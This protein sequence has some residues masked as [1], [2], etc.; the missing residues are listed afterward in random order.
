MK[1]QWDK[2]YLKYSLY[3]SLTIILAIIFYQVLDNLKSIYSSFSGSFS[4]VRRILSPFIIGGFIAYILN[5]GVRWFEKN[6]YSHSKFVVGKY[7]FHRMISILTVYILLI[8][9]IAMLIVF[10][11]PQISNNIREIVRRVPEYLNMTSDWL[12]YW[13]KDL[14]LESQYNIAEYIE[15]N[16]K[17]IFNRTSQIL[18][19][20]L[21]NFAV[22]VMNVTSG[23]LNFLL[24]LII[25]FYMLTDK[26]SF[27]EASEKFLRAIMK[28]EKVDRI[29]DF[30]RDAD[31]LFSKFII[32][33]SLDSF[34][35]G[36]ICLIGLSIM[37]IRYALL[38]S[39]IIGITNMIPYFGPFIGG[40]PATII[41]FFDSPIK[42]IWVLI[43]ILAL[44]QFD[45][46]ILG[47]KILG[48]S[49]GLRPFWIIFAIVVG[50]KLAG[51]LGM[52]LGVPIFAIFRLL[53]VRFID[54]QL[55]IKNNKKLQGDS[56]GT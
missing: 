55:E 9:F 54:R 11:A 46:L 38:L 19:Y 51:V 8:S 23:V 34:I 22:S 24:G 12:E 45:G 15:Q 53:V 27:K 6:L 36:V 50:G 43:F 16:V 35:I 26:E 44:Q 33:K 29:K 28:D 2:Q 56:N 47:P 1:I 48:D 14:G 42:A 40:I 31:E 30:G 41:T 32:G 3:A 10:V 39:A 21:E 7:K 49:V 18:Q 4:W 5:P 17:D 37:N 20:L 13:S 25:S 52:F